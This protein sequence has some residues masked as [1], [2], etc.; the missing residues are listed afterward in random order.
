MG[1]LP[2][3]RER[4]TTALAEIKPSNPVVLGG[5]YHSFWTTDIKADARNPASPILAT[6]FV[7]TSITSTG[8][9]HDGL[10]AVMPNN[11]HIRFFDSRQRGYMALDI[12][13]DTINTRYQVIDDVRQRQTQLS[14]LKSWVV[15]NGKAGAVAV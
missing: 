13:P 1:W 15:E 5:D 2:R 3:C 4:L 8:P 11:P 10:M 12:T 7:G 6:E 9:S 14:T